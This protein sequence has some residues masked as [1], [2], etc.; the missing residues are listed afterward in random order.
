MADGLTEIDT[1]DVHIDPPE[2]LDVEV[3]GSVS[4]T[5]WGCI[6]GNIENQKDLVDYVESQTLQDIQPIPIDYI[7]SLN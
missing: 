1:Y 2:S 4:I 6:L 3:D 7:K 5:A